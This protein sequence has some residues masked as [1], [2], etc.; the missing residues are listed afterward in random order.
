MPSLKMLFGK[1]V[2]QLREQ[3]GITQLQLA[4]RIGLSHEQISNIERGLH[5][6]VARIVQERQVTGP[7]AHE[8][9]AAQT[10]LARPAGLAHGPVDVVEGNQRDPR[11]TLGRLRAEVGQPAVVRVRARELELG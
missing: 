1:R 5:G 8:D 4:I 9:P 3:H 7:R 6:L 2:K 10:R 11:M